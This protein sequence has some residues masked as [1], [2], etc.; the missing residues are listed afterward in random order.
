MRELIRYIAALAT[1][2]VAA[3]VDARAQEESP[4]IWQAAASDDIVLL[5]ALVEEDSEVINAGDNFGNSPLHHA[6]WTGA[7]KAMQWLIDKG[8]DI[9]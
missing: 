4:T 3:A 1:L 6:A 7:L 2:V 5:Q 9:D 8:A